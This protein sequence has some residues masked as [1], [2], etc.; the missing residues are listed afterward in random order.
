ML[1][2]FRIVIEF[3]GGDFKPDNRVP[4]DKDVTNCRFPGIQNKCYGL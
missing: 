2:T 1:I 4:K 3:R